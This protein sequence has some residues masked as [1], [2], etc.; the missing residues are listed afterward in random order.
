M[1][2]KPWYYLI[3]EHYFL[4]I[5]LYPPLKTHSLMTNPPFFLQTLIIYKALI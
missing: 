3:S 4:I 2:P 1:R 5:A